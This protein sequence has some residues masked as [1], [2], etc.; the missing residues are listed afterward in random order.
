MT[1]TICV[2]AGAKRGGY[3]C[4]GESAE[5]ESEEEIVLDAGDGDESDD[6]ES[7]V[8]EEA[9]ASIEADD[10]DEGQTLLS[11]TGLSLD[12]LEKIYNEFI[13]AV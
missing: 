4:P 7:A 9:E 2:A 11:Q 13:I 10:G 3:Q 1:S 12:I 5:V 8:Q 6:E